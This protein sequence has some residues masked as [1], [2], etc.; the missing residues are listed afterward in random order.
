MASY[1]ELECRILNTRH[2]HPYYFHYKRDFA[3]GQYQIRNEKQKRML[4][5]HSFRNN[6]SNINSEGLTVIVHN[7]KI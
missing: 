4:K 3:E 6:S 1:K 2:S 7:V 5:K